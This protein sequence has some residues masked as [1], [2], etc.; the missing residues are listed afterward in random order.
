MSHQLADRHRRQASTGFNFSHGARV[1][2]GDAAV[3]AA[4]RV[5]HLLDDVGDHG[6]IA[7]RL[8][9]LRKSEATEDPPERLC[10]GGGCFVP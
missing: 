3:L 10:N 7:V 2:G 4:M 9:D 8:K 5:N 6:G 1:V